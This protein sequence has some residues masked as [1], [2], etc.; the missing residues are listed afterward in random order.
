MGK[1]P[2]KYSGLFP[3]GK[4]IRFLGFIQDSVSFH[5]RQ[6]NLFKKRSPVQQVAGAPPTARFL[7]T[8]CHQKPENNSLQ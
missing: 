6:S 8:I 5:I 7:E 3:F 2:E 1:I 4:G